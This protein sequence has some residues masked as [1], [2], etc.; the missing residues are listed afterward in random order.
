MHSKTALMADRVMVT[1]GV[2]VTRERESFGEK[3]SESGRKP[4]V[5]VRTPNALSRNGE[6]RDRGTAQ[7]RPA[8]FAGETSRVYLRGSPV[9]RKAKKLPETDTNYPQPG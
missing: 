5:Y 4:R 9:R 7:R 6:F 8:I 2:A 3:H 1:G